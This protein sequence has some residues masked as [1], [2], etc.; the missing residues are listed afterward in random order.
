MLMIGKG[1]GMFGG[2][3]MQRT[4]SGPKTKKDLR[5]KTVRF[6]DKK[7]AE[8]IGKIIDYV[9]W[10][11]SL[12]SVTITY[13]VDH[14]VY[15]KMISRATKETYCKNQLVKVYYDPRHPKRAFFEAL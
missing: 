1:L 15:V 8:T 3:T 14:K 9:I 11:G 6:K 7:T 2:E 10:R 12:A 5:G 13:E 4:G